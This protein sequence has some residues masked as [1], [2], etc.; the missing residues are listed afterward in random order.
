VLNGCTDL[1]HQIF[2]DAGKP[3]RMAFGASELP[4]NMAVEIKMTAESNEIA[5]QD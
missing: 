3:A 4:F 5:P 1:F 2:G